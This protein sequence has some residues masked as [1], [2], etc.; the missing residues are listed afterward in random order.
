MRKRE[1]ERERVRKREEERGRKRGRKSEREGEG[2][3]IAILKGMMGALVP[4]SYIVQYSSH[5]KQK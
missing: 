5:H 2:E 1:E 4:F 3:I